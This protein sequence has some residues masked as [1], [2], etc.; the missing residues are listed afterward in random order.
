M[1]LAQDLIKV[2]NLQLA[3]KLVS[4][5]VVLGLHNSKRS[6]TGAEF[7]QYRHY[8]PGDDP[9]S[10][11]WKLFAR[12]EK[13]QV[14]ESATESTLTINFIIDLSGSMNYTENGVSRLYFAEILLASFAY[15]GFK[16]NDE[17][18]LFALKNG[19]LEILA[20]QG[21][22][23]FQKILYGLENA[24]AEGNWSFER[25]NFPEFQS[26]NKELL[27][28]AS[29]F[30]QTDNEFYELIN[31]WSRP[32]KQILLYQILGEKEV[33]FDWEG[34][35]KF[36]DLET[37][38]DKELSPNETRNAYLKSFNAYLDELESELKIEN[39]HFFRCQLN[40]PI[41]EVLKNSLKMLKWS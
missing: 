24:K 39:V 1:S 20:S 17:M 25:V 29:D 8:R 3:A 33:N 16:Q 13:H 23:S 6:G 9:K 10:I 2:N 41:A 11:D 26:K 30:F 32:G 35:I 14:R 28:F 5:Q 34:V 40:D 38:K 7:E 37:G 27:I 21:K 15:L 12:T 4:D 18:N 36:R 19:K 31:R 22:Q